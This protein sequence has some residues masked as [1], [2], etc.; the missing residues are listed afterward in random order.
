MKMVGVDGKVM[1]LEEVTILE[2]VIG[3]MIMETT[4]KEK[5]LVILQIKMAISVQED[6]NIGVMFSKTCVLTV[7]EYKAIRSWFPHN[8]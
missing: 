1:M 3:E 8:H 6:R 5:D 7:K 4:R 2:E